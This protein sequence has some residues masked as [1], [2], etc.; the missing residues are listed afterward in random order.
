MRILS[1]YAIRLNYSL[2][3]DFSKRYYVTDCSIKKS[4]RS[5]IRL[6]SMCCNTFWQ[7]FICLALFQLSNTSLLVFFV[8][9]STVTVV[10][11]NTKKFIKILALR[12]YF[13]GCSEIYLNNQIR[14]KKLKEKKRT[15]VFSSMQI[16]LIFVKSI[17]GTL[18][19]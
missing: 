9:V 19:I 18:K 16:L 12:T 6:W 7:Y 5:S 15:K 3:S 10:K 11:G 1:I 14:V 17:I 4:G 13:T 8:V 2:A